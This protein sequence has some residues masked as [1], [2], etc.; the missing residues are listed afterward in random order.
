MLH[1][2]NKHNLLDLQK[3]LSR[4]PRKKVKWKSGWCR[5]TSLLSKLTSTADF[6]EF[7]DDSSSVD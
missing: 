1:I 3:C 4:E 5:L 6:F 2:I 7:M